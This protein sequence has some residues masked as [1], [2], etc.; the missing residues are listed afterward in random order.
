LDRSDAVATAGR[1]Q[2]MRDSLAGSVLKCGFS[3]PSNRIEIVTLPDDQFELIAPAR[4]TGIY[5]EDPGGPLVGRSGQVIVRQDLSFAAMQVFQHELG[6]RLVASCFPAAPAWLHEGLA[7]FLETGR[8]DNGRLEL[9]LPRFLINNDVQRAGAGMLRGLV[10]EYL[11]ISRLA[12]VNGLVRMTHSEFHTVGARKDLRLSPEHAN[13]A[14]AWALVHYLELGDAALGRRFHQFLGA[15]HSGASDPVAAWVSAFGS[16]NLDPGL[17]RYLEN[18]EGTYLELKYDPPRRG[19]AQV[20]ELS[21][22]EMEIEWAWWLPKRTPEQRADVRA[23]IERA[24]QD[25]QSYAAA[26]LLSAV[27]A[28]GN[29]DYPAAL[30]ILRATLR[31]EPELEHALALFVMTSAGAAKA[32][33]NTPSLELASVAER[34]R[35]RPNS[36]RAQVALAQ[37]ELVYGSFT[38]GLKH[39]QQAVTVAPQDWFAWYTL[40]AALLASDY[41]ED[42]VWAC[43]RALN[44]APHDAPGIQ[45]MVTQLQTAIAN[46]PR[47]PVVAPAD[48]QV[49][50]QLP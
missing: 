19:E 43:G 13:Y 50:Q 24:A 9:G 8:V 2:A 11:P 42:A 46:H 21:L 49:L 7:S 28:M 20:R 45:H 17:K 22:G 29:D 5:G 12:S 40:A 30:E 25:P 32:A 6:H 16:V 48:Q 23:R 39:G 4:F 44:L 26:Q 10:V 15:L 37:F 36:V 18:F 33:K 1:L 14:T 47:G 35:K 41:T 3:A 31:R 27:I 34:L 38:A